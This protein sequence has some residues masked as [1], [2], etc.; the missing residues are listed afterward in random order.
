MDMQSYI[1]ALSDMARM[2]RGNYH[3]TLGQAIQQL[4]T[5]DPNLP[6]RFDNGDSPG[7]AMSYRGYYSDLAISPESHVD[8][9]SVSEFLATLK[10]ALNKTFTGYKG[11]DFTMG[12]DAPL[13]C[14]DYSMLGLAIMDL[15]VDDKGVT[16]L[17]K[18]ID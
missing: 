13:W 10:G 6:V 7:K 2:T 15:Q 18:D 17:T 1:N 11:G 9:V 14:A 12:E 8:P 3:L 16:I 5:T 4:S